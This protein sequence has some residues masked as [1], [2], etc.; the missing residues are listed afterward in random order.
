MEYRIAILGII[1]NYVQIEHLV[2]LTPARYL[3]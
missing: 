2:A 3:Y 1:V